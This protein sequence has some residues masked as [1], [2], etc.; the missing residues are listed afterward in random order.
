MAVSSRRS[1][2]FL[3]WTFLLAASA[4]RA[5][6]QS[7]AEAQPPLP[8][9]ANQHLP[10][11]LRVR[12]EFRGRLEGFTGGGFTAG[13]DD[14]YW[15]NRLRLN[16]TARP[17]PRLAFEVQAQDAR[18]GGK[19]G[20]PTGPPFRDAFD[21]RMAYAEVGNPQ[22]DLV[23]ARIGRQEL[24][25]GEQRLVG[26]VSWLNTARTFDGARLTI[27]RAG[28]QLDAFGSS[29][30]RIQNGTFNRSGYGN[31]FLGVHGTTQALARRGV[32]EAYAFL[33]RDPGLRR[34]TMGTRW[35]GPLPRHLDYGT[36]VAVQTGSA[37]TSTMRAW[38]GHWQLGK[39]IA[40]SPTLRLIG[41]YNYASKTFDNL[42]P[43]AHDKYGLADQVGWR[44]IHHIR[45]GGEVTLAKGWQVTGSGHS[46]RL[47]DIHDGLYNAAG[48]LIARFPGTPVT[49][50]VG[51]EID[52]QVFHALAAQI[53]LAGG[54]SRI[55]P[56]TFLERATP[57]A[58]YSFPY[59][60][61]TYIFLADK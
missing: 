46:W 37:G 10:A 5:Q 57:G 7:P 42:Y 32:V 18:V 33:K 41:E 16:A 17:G 23:T 22:K 53:S 58:N 25:F 19:D 14:L 30:V 54:Y 9:R 47:A 44:N 40:A 34:V 20:Q 35:A 60:M 48:A 28:Y 51:E 59:L 43:T 52:V 39:T 12:G 8:N 50:H 31:R 56:G 61:V 2:W 29:L 38:A 36:E 15:L 24:V 26:H 11:W 4:A 6:E 13:R 27:R 49:G 21:L 55:F 45:F 1:V 3:V